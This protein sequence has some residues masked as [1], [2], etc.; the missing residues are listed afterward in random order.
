LVAALVT[1]A[2]VAAGLPSLSGGERAGLL[3][4][5]GALAGLAAAVEVRDRNWHHSRPRLRPR[6]QLEGASVPRTAGRP[7]HSDLF[8]LPPDIQDFTGRECDLV[9]V[10]ESLE[11]GTAG[12]TAVALLAI[13]G[14]P[15]VGKTTLAVHAAHRLRHSFPDGQLYVN[16]RGAEAQ[17]LDPR[18]VL[19]GFLRELGI[20]RAAVPES[21]DDR[22]RLFRSRLDDRRALV[23]LDNAADEGQVRPLL[24]G[25]AGC[26]VLVTS[27]SI[28]AGLAGATQ[29]DL[30][31]LAPGQ[32]TD[33][34]A[35]IVGDTRVEL[36][37]GSA[38]E[39]ARLCGYLP[40]AV[41]IAGSRLATRRHWS[42]ASFASRLGDERGRLSELTVGDLEVRASLAL[43]YQGLNEAEQRMFRL[44]G[45]L[46]APDFPTWV[47]A[48][49]LGGDLPTAEALVERLVDMRLLEA[50]GPGG[51]H[52]SRH[53]FH[54]LL[55]V[56][57]RE[58][59]RE[60][61][62]EPDRRTALE[63]ALRAYVAVA[64]EAYTL[65]DPAAVHDPG[66]RALRSWPAEDRG[67]MDALLRDPVRWFALERPSL[68]VA[69]EQ[70]CQEGLRELACRLAIALYGSFSVGA[71]WHAWQRVYHLALDAARQLGDRRAEA[72]VLL[73]LGDVYKNSG[74]VDGPGGTP[75][76]DREDVMAAGWLEQSRA[77]FHRLGDHRREAAALRRLGGVYRDLGSM[78][79]AQS[80]YEQG[81]AL[82]RGQPDSDLMR[83][84]LLR[85]FG[86]LHRMT[87]H[88]D[89]AVTCFD[90]T[91]SVVR[92]LGDRRG[93]LGALR[94]LGETYLRQRRWEEAVVCFGRH[95][96]VDRQLADRH[97][98][99]HA[100]RG[101]GEA[102]L[103][104]RHY[105]EAIACFEQCLP[106]FREIGHRS[107]EAETLES[108]GS[109]LFAL[110]RLSAARA[111]WSQ[112]AA[113]FEELGMARAAEVR[114]RLEI[115][116]VLG[117]LRAA[118]R[119]LVSR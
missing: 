2:G 103:G 73:R 79:I 108:L 96:V 115:T 89:E 65:V 86:A 87:G 82:V 80:C 14:K 106:R 119:R 56:F 22:A 40:L 95:L 62:P 8:Q 12:R 93:E 53:R 110:G 17:A 105:R 45:L 83:A 35:G 30:G 36:E 27:R 19:A 63:L 46:D 3:V 72:E 23:V 16:L 97:A 68:I 6:W 32:A 116:G 114:E 7:F 99:A 88:Y 74:R 94:G 47:A 118:V 48:A 11:G 55:R 39:I 29:I 10:I 101:L 50:T 5:A 71:H 85:G 37:S 60:E 91:L 31:E 77:A 61:E 112:S 25:G 44:L 78:D 42:L 104:Q 13:S 64:E 98:E 20:A 102:R 76:P 113:I 9:R 28:L 18:E 43:S 1:V 117:F 90:E 15:G 57:A 100:L 69:V 59:L 38:A 70:S 21:L 92:R 84:Y 4:L 33:L 66:A 54:D 52:Q 58:R 51:T 34:L 107:S 41:R 109:A 75:E 49:L 81:L 24:P 67:L 111:S 26:A